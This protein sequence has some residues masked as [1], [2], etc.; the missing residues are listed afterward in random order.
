[1]QLMQ[2]VDFLPSV[3]SLPTIPFVKWKSLTV[4]FISIL[5]YVVMC[6]H[7][8]LIEVWVRILAQII[9]AAKTCLDGFVACDQICLSKD[10]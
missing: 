5:L 8:F 4:R 7:T 6:Q 9:K 3:A 10:S 2:S 1:M